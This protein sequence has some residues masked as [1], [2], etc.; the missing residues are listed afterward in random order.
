MGRNGVKTGRIYIKLY[1]SIFI[2]QDFSHPPKVFLSAT[3]YG[4]LPKNLVIC[5]KGTLALLLL[6]TA[7]TPHSCLLL[8]NLKLRISPQLLKLQIIENHLKPPKIIFLR[9]Q[10]Y[11]QPPKTIH[12]KTFA[13]TLNQPSPL[14]A[15]RS[16]PEYTQ[17]QL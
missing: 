17:N 14:E 2:R 15:T 1:M 5:F 13:I 6:D 10:S 7:R 12:T 3:F 16:Q 9:T 8:L 11:S 4:E